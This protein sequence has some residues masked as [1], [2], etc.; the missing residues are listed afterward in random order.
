MFSIGI[1]RLLRSIG[2]YLRL[3][4]LQHTIPIVAVLYSPLLEYDRSQSNEA[5]TTHARRTRTSHTS[6]MMI[7]I[8]EHEGCLRRGGHTGQITTLYPFP[9]I[10]SVTFSPADW[11]IFISPALHCSLFWTPF[12]CNVAWYESICLGF[13]HCMGTGTRLCRVG[14]RVI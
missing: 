4:Y 9:F 2:S 6:R 7:E 10:I 12:A 11:S 13:M 5:S 3:G 1:V 14:L 8:C